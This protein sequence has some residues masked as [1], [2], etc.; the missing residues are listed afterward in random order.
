MSLN[1]TG[2]RPVEYKVL[3]KPDAVNGKTSGGI[4]MPENAIERQ[5]A[6][7]DTGIL[8]DAS[9]MAFSDW[10]GRKPELGDRVV[11][12]RYAGSIYQHDK[13]REKFRLMND[14]DICAIMEETG[15][16][17]GIKDRD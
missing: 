7:R 5:E 12:S 14:K 3:I 10:K 11:F 8:V 15:N 2:I 16:G 1:P 9:E 17:A 4:L 13:T 6:I